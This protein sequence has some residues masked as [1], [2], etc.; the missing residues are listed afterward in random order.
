MQRG[1]SF[2]RI[3]RAFFL[4]QKV[5]FS[6]RPCWGHSPF[7]GLSLGFLGLFRSFQKPLRPNTLK[8]A[9]QRRALSAPPHLFAM[10]SV[11]GRKC[12]PCGPT[13]YPGH[14]YQEG[15]YLPPD[16]GPGFWPHYAWSQNPPDSPPSHICLG[17]HPVSSDN[18]PGSLPT[19]EPD[20]PVWGHGYVPRAPKALASPSVLLHDR[21][22]RPRSGLSLPIGDL[23][24]SSLPAA[25]C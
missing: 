1:R 23:T 5:A 24:N 2:Y 21:P 8:G 10:A 18:N 16:F 4:C 7:A 17:G 3:F 19:C 9:A 20:L 11:P 22:L 14:W 15:P 13:S 12:V 25:P 6:V